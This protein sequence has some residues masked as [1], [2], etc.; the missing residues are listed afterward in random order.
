[1]NTNMVN[2][3]CKDVSKYVK[4]NTDYEVTIVQK[5]LKQSNK[6]PLISITEEDNSNVI[7]STDFRDKTDLINISVNIYA[8]D[9]VLGNTTISNVNIVKELMSLVDDVLSR[10]YRLMR[11]SCRPTPNLDNTIYRITARYTKKILSNKN[12][13]I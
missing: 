9:M 7:V 1:M 12:L 10:K 8:Q 11:T 6:F 13:L 4:A 3:L 2:Q 5:S